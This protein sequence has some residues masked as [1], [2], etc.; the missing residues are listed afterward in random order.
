MNKKILLLTSILGGISIVLLYLVKEN[1]VKEY[2]N[3]DDLKNDLENDY[4]KLI[5]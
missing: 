1:K 2:K 4:Y 5:R 3:I